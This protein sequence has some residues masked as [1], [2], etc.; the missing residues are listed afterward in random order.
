CGIIT[1][2]VYVSSPRTFEKISDTL[3]N[4]F[5]GKKPVPVVAPAKEPEP[6]PAKKTTAARRRTTT[7]APA[8][9]ITEQSP[10]PGEK[11]PRFLVDPTHAAVKTDA[12][13]VYSYNSMTSSV[14]EVLKKG[15]QV[16]TNLEVID[17][18]R[19]WI[20]VRK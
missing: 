7:G 1:V 11:I 19:R 8:E 9:A 16:E 18:E 10:I 5:V 15:E 13:P 4:A 3:S 6:A 2:I 12:A 17:S 20:L 14:V